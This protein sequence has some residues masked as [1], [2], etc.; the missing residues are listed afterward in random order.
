MRILTHSLTYC[1]AAFLCLFLLLLPFSPAFAGSDHEPDIQP[2]MVI[3]AN[4]QF[5]FA[6]HYFSTR[7]YLRAVDEYKRFIYFF[8]QDS[9]VETAMFRIGRSNFLDNQFSAAIKAFR[10]LIDRY[11]ET[12]LSIKAYWMISESQMQLGASGPAIINLNNLIAISD[13]MDVRDEAYYR[14]GWIY[15]ETASWE[16]A[17]RYFAK[18]SEPNKNKYRIERLTADLDKQKLIPSKN[19]ALAGILSVIPGAGFLYCERYQDALVAFLLN[20]A[21]MYAA[22]DAFDDGNDALG[23]VIAF[24]EFGFYAG[25]I[26]GAVASAHKYNRTKTDQFIEK[27]KENHMVK[28]SAGF[29]G[30]GFRLAFQVPF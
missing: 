24:V 8:P 7:Q 30:K 4:Q 20:G 25:N 9:R 28:L 29:S 27:I 2:F 1:F 11:G 18:I 15:L 14:I 26:Y 3:D 16:N 17:R 19:P 22:Y 12:E 10:S 6:E 13:D 21:L 23:G 5:E